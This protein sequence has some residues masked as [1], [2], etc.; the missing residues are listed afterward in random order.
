[1]ATIQ[2]RGKY[3]RAQVRRR[4]WGTQ[5]R[6]FDKRGEAEAWARQVESEMDRGTYISRSEAERTTLYE[7]LTRYEREISPSKRSTTAYC[8]PSKI[9]RWKEDP[10]SK[11]ALAF[12]RSADIA[13]WRDARTNEGYAANTVRIWLALLS[14]V[15]TIARKEWGME[16]LVNPVLS[17]RKPSLVGTARERR[18]VGDEE[19]RI[20]AEARRIDPELEVILILAIETGMRR[21]EL[22][23]AKWEDLNENLTVLTVPLSSSAANKQG[24]HIPLSNRAREAILTLNHKKTGKLFTYKV[25]CISKGF[26]ATYKNLGIKGLRLHDLRH[27]AASRFFE[28]GLDT[29]EVA[30]ITG[31]KTLQMLRRYTH[32]K[33]ENLA[34]KL[35]RSG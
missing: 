22:A 10:L 34:E 8:E 15:Y 35:N 2:R 21:G 18:L 31:H 3:W 13:A 16:S 30:S 1:M 27:E 14:H 5:S 28:K 12:I 25:D 9:K 26:E 23:N 4:G 17:I 19:A 7:A 33:A 20:L 24:R 29:M 11:R 32:L 6:S